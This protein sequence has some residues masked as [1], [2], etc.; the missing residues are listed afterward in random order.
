MFHICGPVKDLSKCGR[1]IPKTLK[2]S[3]ISSLQGEPIHEMT[4]DDMDYTRLQICE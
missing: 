4:E 2:E 3:E 1:S